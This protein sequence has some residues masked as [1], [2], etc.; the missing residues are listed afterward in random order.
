MIDELLE[1]NNRFCRGISDHCS[2]RI[3]RRLACLDEQ[4]PTVA[5]LSCADARVDPDVVFDVALGDLFS[6][7]VAGTVADE[8]AI[9]SLRFAVEHLGVRTVVVLGHERC[10]AVAAATASTPTPGLDAVVEPI[11][12]ALASAPDQEPVRRNTCVQARRVRSAFPDEVDV[13]AAVYV[14]DTGEV[15]I[16]DVVSAEAA[17]G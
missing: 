17:S 2:D 16:H 7:R 4:R 12:Q 15:S 3:E 9:A 8:T 13:I 10:G 1:G 14:P 11:R 6:V 5:V